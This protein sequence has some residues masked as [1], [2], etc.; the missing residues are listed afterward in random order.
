[1]SF[2]KVCIVGPGAVG[3]MMAV[4]LQRVGYDVSALARPEKAALL[5]A[6]G[7][8]LLDGGQTYKGTPRAASDPKDL[9][10]QDLLIITVKGDGLAWALPHLA[11]LS[12]TQTQ[13]VFVMNGVPWWFFSHFGGK[14]KGLALKSVD[15]DGKLA[16]S[17]PLERL[18]WGV[19]N[20][21][22]AILDDGTLQHEHSKE[23]QFGRPDQTKDG[24]PEIC[25]VFHDAGYSAAMPDKIHDSIWGKLLSNMMFNPIS[26]LTMATS[27]LM[28]ADPLVR[29]LCI[30]VTDEGRAVGA[31]LGIPTGLSGAERFPVG[32]VL[33]AVKT[34]MLADVERGRSLEVEPIIGVVVEIA[35]L[36]GVP[37][38]YTT[39]LYGLLRVRAQSFASKP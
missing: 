21:R 37:I 24:L 35:T 36:C 39:M 29:D 19:V 20:C 27:D 3:G 26:A 13:W 5:N 38:P 18:V 14:L 17:V 6:K 1:M 32:R 23:L 15:P 25:T 22:V 34:S 2:K 33:P 10:P 7:I 4:H 11:A 28:M 12:H 16:S 30:K 31:A 8:T 9:G